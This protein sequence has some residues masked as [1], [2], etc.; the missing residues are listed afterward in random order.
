MN[1]MRE[2]T[3]EHFPTVLLT[4]LSIVQALALELLWSYLHENESLFEWTWTAFQ[5]WMQVGAT[6]MAL[7]LVLVAYVANVMRFSWVPET[8]DTVFPFA[9]GI[10]EFML[11]DTLGADN[12]DHWFLLMA[13]IFTM[14]HWVAHKTMVKA[15]Q[16]KENAL[17]FEGRAPAEL[18][19]FYPQIGSVSLMAG[20]GILLMIFPEFSILSTLGLI[21]VSALLLYQYYSSERFWKMSIENQPPNPQL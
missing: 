20:I 19:D 12:I 14:M 9:I 3:K 2:R 5:T 10:L 1:P 7:I 8:S 4:L 17:F 21:G 11:I 15:R 6:F 16:E 18:K 13:G